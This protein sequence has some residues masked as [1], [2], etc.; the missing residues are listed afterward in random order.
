MSRR[1]N[2]KRREQRKIREPRKLG[3]LHHVPGPGDVRTR[4]A[5][6]HSRGLSLTVLPTGLGD[7]MAVRVLDAD[8]DAS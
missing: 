1:N 5:V 4:W 6:V 3:H 2:R 8:A 7:T